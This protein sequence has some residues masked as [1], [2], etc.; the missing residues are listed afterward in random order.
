MRITG[1]GNHDFLAPDFVHCDGTVLAGHG[2]QAQ[3]PGET[4]RRGWVARACV[5]VVT[6]IGWVPVTVGLG[7]GPDGAGRRILQPG[8]AL[9]LLRPC[10][11]TASLR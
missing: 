3:R 7:P 11:F 4:A 6:S 2:A 10:L 8:E 1:P 9:I 5:V